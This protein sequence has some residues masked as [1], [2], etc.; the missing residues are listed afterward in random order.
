MSENKQRLEDY[1]TRFRRNIVGIDQVYP[2][3][4]GQ[5]KII[6]CDW[7]ASGRLYGPIEDKMVSAFGPLVGNTHTETF[8]EPG[9]VMTWAYH[10]AQ[11]IIQSDTSM[12][13][14]MMC[15]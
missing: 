12:P 7:I 2:T 14:R 3:P 4:Y 5:K 6:Y 13:V 11:E 9:S 10:H 15:L 8:G 1:F